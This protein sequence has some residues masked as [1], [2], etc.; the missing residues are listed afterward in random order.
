M[1]YLVVGYGVV[2]LALFLYL[3][4]LDR[5]IAELRKEIAALE[6]ESRGEG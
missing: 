2:W 6:A 4:S 1:T 5:R 3:R